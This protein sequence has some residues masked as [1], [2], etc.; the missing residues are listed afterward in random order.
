MPQTV[1]PRLYP[2]AVY[3]MGG[4]LVE[5]KMVP[6]P[7]PPEREYASLGKQL[8]A[9][10]WTSEEISFSPNSGL[11][12]KPFILYEFPKALRASRDE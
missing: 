12:A 8:R 4:G 1:E 11:D 5:V 9:E 2:C 3:D 6:R 7:H 10:S